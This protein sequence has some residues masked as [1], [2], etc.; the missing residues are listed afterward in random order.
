MA[1]ANGDPISPCFS[2]F[3][4]QRGHPCDNGPLRP[5][6]MLVAQPENGSGGVL[7]FVASKVRCTKKRVLAKDN[8][9]AW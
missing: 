4:G 1:D 2:L 7:A 9:G 8:A 5:L 3:E 6:R